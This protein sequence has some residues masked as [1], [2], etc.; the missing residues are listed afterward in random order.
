MAHHKNPLVTEVPHNDAIAAIVLA[1]GSAYPRV[2]LPPFCQIHLEAF[3]DVA[4]KC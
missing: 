4:K 3:S 1:C 2:L